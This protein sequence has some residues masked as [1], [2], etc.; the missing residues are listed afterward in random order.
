MHPPADCN[1]STN[2]R[3]SRAR[4]G[5]ARTDAADRS[6]EDMPECQ[7]RCDADENAGSA[8]QA[9][10]LDGPRTGVLSPDV[11]STKNQF[12]GRI[13][14]RP[15]GLLYPHLGMFGAVVDDYIHHNAA[16]PARACA[17]TVDS[18]GL[19]QPP[20]PARAPV[21]IKLG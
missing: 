15:V 5:S 18:L 21:P 3:R 2:L 6:L 10:R 8:S 16:A 14:E 1:R 11:R 4:K 7:R 19:D 9:A 12:A 20:L 17:R 13:A